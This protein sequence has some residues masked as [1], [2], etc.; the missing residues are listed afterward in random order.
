[1]NFWNDS[2]PLSTILTRKDIFSLEKIVEKTSHNVAKRFE[3]K[4]R[5]FI[6]EG[7]WADLVLVDLNQKYEVTEE[8]LLYKCKWSPF[9]GQTFNSR[10]ISTFVNGYKVFE[11]TDLLC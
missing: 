10:I 9:I 4:E 7:Y 8:S 11:N 6:R 2:T 3:I 5:G 1:M